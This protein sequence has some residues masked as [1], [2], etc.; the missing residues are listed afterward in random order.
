MR[1]YELRIAADTPGGGAMYSSLEDAKVAGWA[2]I[3]PVEGDGPLALPLEGFFT[4]HE[5]R[6]DGAAPVLVFDSRNE[7]ADA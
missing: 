3:G 7:Q 2:L 5:S 4:V 6:S 1:R